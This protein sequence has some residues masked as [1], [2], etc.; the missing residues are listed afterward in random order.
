V[1]TKFA[2]STSALCDNGFD[3][4]MI[5][6]TSSIVFQTRVAR[7]YIFKP[8]ISMWVNFGGPWNVNSWYILWPFEIYYGHLMAIW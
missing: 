7:W 3:G 5:F 8:K 4:K 6:F 1:E 2:I